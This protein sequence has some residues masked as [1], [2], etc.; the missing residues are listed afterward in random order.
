M[1]NSWNRSKNDGYV[2]KNANSG[3]RYA[4]YVPQNG[5]SGTRYAKYV[6]ENAK[7]GTHFNLLKTKI[8]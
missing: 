8:A 3:T 1:E 4:K 2:P 5:K 7:S 6:P